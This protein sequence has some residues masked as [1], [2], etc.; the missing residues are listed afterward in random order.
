MATF[1]SGRVHVTV[2]ATSANLGPGFDSL[3]LALS[4]RDSLEAQVTA[5]GLVVEVEGAGADD[6]PRDESHLVVRA[7]R[8]AFA[9][10]EADPP[11]LR[12]RCH[13][14]IPHSRG[15]G[16]SSAAIVAGLALA[17]A[18]VAGGQLL[19]DDDAL[20][21]LAAELEGHPDNVAPAFYGGFVI[22][23]QE[24][25]QWYAVPAGVDPRVRAVVFVP[26]TPVATE[27]ARGLLPDAVPH[28]EAAAN[29]GRA[30]LLV[31]ALAGRPEHLFAA[32]RDFLH[33]EQR[34]PAM[35]ESLALMHALR[36]EGIA[37]V[38]S[39]AGPTVLA[40]SGGNHLDLAGR[41]PAG[42]ACHELDIEAAGV[43]L[44]PEDSR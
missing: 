26:P 33:Q 2:P 25:G 17:R 14:V 28:A 19:L 10:M 32:T 3:G 36:A 12:L 8:A 44:G 27:V 15:L 39:G 11:G 30:A 18:L 29:S 20:F 5:A 43:V 34:T 7:M 38:I 9:E 22:S 1:V 13:N 6:V 42:W 40:F 35:P 24:G 21:R 41:V 4:L 31:A 16:S 23:G 37:A